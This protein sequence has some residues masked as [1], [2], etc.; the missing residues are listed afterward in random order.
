MGHSQ[1]KVEPHRLT[2]NCRTPNR[3]QLSVI[4]A[5]MAATLVVEIIHNDCLTCAAGT[6]PSDT[7]SSQ[8]LHVP[9]MLLALLLM[10]TA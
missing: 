1:N 7:L 6:G 5:L 10:E 4:L 8:V 3:H 2:I 9:D